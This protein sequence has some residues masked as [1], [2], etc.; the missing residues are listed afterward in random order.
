M[1]GLMFLR[2]TYTWFKTQYREKDIQIV[3]YINVADIVSIQSCEE[4]DSDIKSVI[5]I[6]SEL[7]E[8]YYSDKTP[9]ELMAQIR[10]PLFSA[11]YAPGAY[12][13]ESHTMQSNEIGS[14]GHGI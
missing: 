8:S 9:D 10:N 4:E 11:N 3:R 1:D 12:L 6:R 13:G 5:F 7:N 14:S 2:T